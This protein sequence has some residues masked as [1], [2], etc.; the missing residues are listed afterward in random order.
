MESTS[1]KLP[2]IDA[3]IKDGD[4]ISFG[5]S[6]IEVIHTPG[7]SLGGVCLFFRDEKILF[8]GDTLF[9]GSIG[10][11]DLMGGNYE[12]LINSITSKITSL[13][14]DI[15]IYPGHGN[16]STIGFEKKNNPFL[17]KGKE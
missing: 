4:T 7:H 12:T 17:Q 16:S 9:N 3:F 5:K 8:T 11:T 15:T 6:N 14:D 13:G 2:T 10:R 1:I